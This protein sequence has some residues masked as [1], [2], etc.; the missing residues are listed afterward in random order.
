MFAADAS[1]IWDGHV[2]SGAQPIKDFLSTVLPITKHE[3][4]SLDVQ[5]ITLASSPG[6]PVPLLITVAGDVKFGVREQSHG[7]V[8]TFIIS[9]DASRPTVPNTT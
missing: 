7:F 4:I 5:P 2:Y 8:H 9:P 1:L 3:I 6:A